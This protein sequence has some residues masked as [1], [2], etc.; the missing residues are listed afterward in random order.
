[1]YTLEYYGVVKK[2]DSRVK[3]ERLLSAGFKLV[4]EPMKAEK[5]KTEKTKEEDTAEEVE[6]D[7]KH[8]NK[9][10]IMQILDERGIEYNPRHT[11]DEL[12]EL[13]G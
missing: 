12:I 1:M 7:F 3:A 4:E 8:L 9:A 10:E 6:L 5:T 13:L 11:K 2:T